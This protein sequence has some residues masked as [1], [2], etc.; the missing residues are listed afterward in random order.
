MTALKPASVTG[1]TSSAGGV[2]SFSG[3]LTV[4][5]NGVFSTRFNHYKI[6]FKTT[7]G[8]GTGNDIVMKMRAAGSDS[9]LN[10]TFQRLLATAGSVQALGAVNQSTG[11]LLT[12]YTAGFTSLAIELFSPFANESTQGQ[13]TFASTG[14]TMS[15]GT[16]GL[17]QNTSFQADGFTLSSAA[18]F[19]GTV[20]VFGYY[21]G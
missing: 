18:A 11:W 16:T 5:V 17:F 9:S 14:A 7:A 4:S 12:G 20:Q 13:A 6:M 19:T 3:A 1:G 21:A 8:G 10:Y 2:V 15:N